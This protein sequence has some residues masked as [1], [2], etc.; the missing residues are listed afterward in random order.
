MSVLVKIT[1][2]PINI[3]NFASVSNYI[4]SG[5]TNLTNH[6]AGFWRPNA[7][8]TKKCGNKVNFRVRSKGNL[9]L[10]CI[11]LP[12]YHNRKVYERTEAEAHSF[13]TR[14]SWGAGSRPGSLAPI[15]IRYNVWVSDSVYA[16]G[17]T[18]LSL[19][20]PRFKARF[21]VLPFCLSLFSCN[22]SFRRFASRFQFP[23]YHRQT[24]IF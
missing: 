18:V 9:S 8:N 3:A 13:N 10:W 4:L 14:W 1:L 21:F 12:V 20:V 23:L 22:L 2:L 7:T 15:H 19:S 6:T 24:C 16:V 5:F 11:W 17:K